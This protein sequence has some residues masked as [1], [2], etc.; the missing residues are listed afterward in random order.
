MEERI[1]EY[2]HKLFNYTI[3][4]QVIRA[5]IREYRDLFKGRIC[6]IFHNRFHFVQ[7]KY[8]TNKYQGYLSILWIQNIKPSKKD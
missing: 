3:D 8:T 6:D 7:L 2:C 1:T 5:E 4:I